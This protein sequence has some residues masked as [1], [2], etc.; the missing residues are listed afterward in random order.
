MRTNE[1]GCLASCQSLLQCQAQGMTDCTIACSCACSCARN[2]LKFSSCRE[3]AYG[4][5]IVKHALI[6]CIQEMNFALQSDGEED[7]LETNAFMNNDA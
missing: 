7:N 6:P 1:V 4:L 3:Q 2:A 5:A